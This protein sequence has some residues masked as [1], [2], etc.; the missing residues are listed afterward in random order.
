M[1]KRSVKQAII[2]V[3][4]YTQSAAELNQPN[5]LREELEKY[6]VRAE[7]VRN[8]PGA[9][10]RDGDF[11]VFL[12]KDKY[13]ARALEKRMRLFNR[14]NAIEICDDKMLTYLALEGFPMPE[15]ISSL[16]C[17]TP[18]RPVSGTLLDETER[19]LGYP[20]VVKENFGSLGK[21]V[22]LV[23]D[24]AS[25]EKISER[26]KLL[27]HLYQKFVAESSGRDVRAVCV[28]GEIVA[29][30]LRTHESDFRS[31]ISVGGQGKKFEA[32]GE[33]RALCREVS[34][35][36]GL[37]YCG[38]DLL[39]GKDGWLVCEVNSNAFFGGI[40]GVTGVNVARAYAG[41]IMREIYG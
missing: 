12:D 27:P 16:L 38:I 17:Y 20:L 37:D 19:R 5:R 1:R 29:C 25:L 21:Q 36:L 30:M 8:S 41:H 13:A 18:E 28:A 6:G 7:I 34:A 23:R 3:N 15:T 39:F 35:R 2:L 14:A 40:E 11:C 26:L 22:Y 31:N 4:A 10:S 33:M 9:L 24:R 32:T